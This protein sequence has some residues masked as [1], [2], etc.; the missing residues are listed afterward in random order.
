MTLFA[1]P[2]SH[3]FPHKYDFSV[4]DLCDLRVVRRTKGARL[5]TYSNARSANS[6]RTSLDSTNSLFHLFRHYPAL[7]FNFFSMALLQTLFSLR[8]FLPRASF[9]LNKLRG[10]AVTFLV[11]LFVVC[12]IDALITDDEP[13]FEPVEWS[14]TQS[15]VM[16]IFGLA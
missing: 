4:K 2:I 6:A 1:L 8:S 9:E 16:L 3:L 5:D 14:L 13:L 15:W 7:Y 11:S 12:F 10:D